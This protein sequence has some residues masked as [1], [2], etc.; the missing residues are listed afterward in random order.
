MRLASLAC[1]T[2]M[3]LFA[4]SYILV[5]A[6]GWT[7]QRWRQP[8]VIV[9]GVITLKLLKA[10]GTRHHQPTAPVSPHD[11]FVFWHCF[12][13]HGLVRRERS[14]AG[15]YSQAGFEYLAVLTVGAAMQEQPIGWLARLRVRS[16]L[17]RVLRMS[18]AAELIAR[19]L[20][21]LKQRRYLV[22]SPAG[23]V[24]SCSIAHCSPLANVS[25]RARRTV[26]GPN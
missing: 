25:D 21:R 4:K 8:T 14:G 6:A 15:C 20:V 9:D 22:V 17:V 12:T 5:I 24:Q 7:H 11:R 2:D 1:R 3:S 10:S 19:S 23:A 18:A 16:A 26:Y 13:T